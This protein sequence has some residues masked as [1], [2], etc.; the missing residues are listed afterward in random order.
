MP[1]QSKELLQ[2]V[3]DATV[4]TVTTECVHIFPQSTAMISRIDDK[5]ASVRLVDISFVAINHAHL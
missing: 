4:A 1:E 5:D 3:T 2:E